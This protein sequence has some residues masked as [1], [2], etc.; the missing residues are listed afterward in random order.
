MS[1]GNISLLLILLSIIM[2]GGSYL[3]VFKPNMEDKKVLEGEVQTLQARYDE[4][5]DKEKHRDELIAETEQFNE[6]FEEIIAKYPATLDQEH[7][8]MFVKGLT[9]DQGDYQFDVNNVALGKP[10]DFYALNGTYTNADGEVVGADYQCY[11]GEFPMAYE[12]S[13]EGLKD[14][15]SYIMAY[16]YRMNIS[17]MNIA[18]DSENDKYSGSVML[19]QYCVSGEDR[20]ADTIN[21]D[22]ENGVD[23]IFLGGEGAATPTTYEY[24]A[25]NGAAIIENNDMHIVL[26]NA[27]NDAADGIIVSAGG[28]DTYVT[29]SANEAVELVIKVTDEDGKKFV[30][31]TIGDKSYTK[32]VTSKD[33]KIYVESSDRVDSDD[34]NS[35]KV[36]LDN[37]TTLPVFF[38]VVGDDSGSPR[39]VM[40]SK[41]GTVKVY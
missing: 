7:T 15:V 32:E 17:S 10:I 33:L 39:F 36:T 28:D 4:L 21:V 20:V 30:T 19:N 14:F 5:C 24:D 3:Y 2:V 34:K 11:R 29:S 12:G 16:K 38:K 40:A 23:N 35:V 37:K 22:V 1:K 31:Y 6:E 18:Y 9:K 41:S 25:D 26:N 27:N 13:Y 8:V